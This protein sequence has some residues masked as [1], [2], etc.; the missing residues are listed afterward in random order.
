MNHVKRNHKPDK[1]HIILLLLCGAVFVWSLIKPF[2]YLIWILE[3]APVVVGIILLIVSRKKFQ[4]TNLVY[5]LITTAIIMVLIGAHYSYV[6][7]PL[8]N[9]IKEFYGLKRNHYDRLAHLW[10]GFIA[11]FALREIL[12]RKFKL[13]N[14]KI[15]GVLVVCICLSLSAMYELIEWA[16]AMMGGSITNDFLG[17][18]GDRWD[19]QWDMLLAFIGS[20]IMVTMFYKVHNKQIENIDNI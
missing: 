10:E 6:R 8:F 4:F 3:A 20:I 13:K 9:W 14:N 12:I 18:Q 17:E 2:S 16:G 5:I 1:I 11:S 15:L 7:V 19:S